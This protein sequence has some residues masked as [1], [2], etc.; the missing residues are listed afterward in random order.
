MKY[1]ISI[2]DHVGSEKLWSS[3]YYNFIQ[4]IAAEY[5]G[6]I[7]NGLIETK[8]RDVYSAKLVDSDVVFDSSESYV[9]FVLKYG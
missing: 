6:M 2:F 3:A 5:M 4:A 7:V 1:S 9:K 8:L